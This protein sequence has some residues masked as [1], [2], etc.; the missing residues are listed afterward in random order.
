MFDNKLRQGISLIPSPN[1]SI[2]D[3]LPNILLGFIHST[4]TTAQ[5]ELLKV[6]FLLCFFHNS[7][8]H[9]SW[10]ILSVFH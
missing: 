5:E 3:S 7:G 2:T 10:D 1:N 9:A 6:F 8:R 4:R